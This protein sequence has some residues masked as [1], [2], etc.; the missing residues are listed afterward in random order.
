MKPNNQGVIMHTLNMNLEGTT[1]A[2]SL[3]MRPPSQDERI[4]HQKAVEVYNQVREKDPDR[5]IAEPVSPKN[6]ELS[7]AELFAE[8]IQHAFQATVKKA[9][10]KTL[11]KINDISLQLRAA[12][13]NNGI[14]ELSEED[15][16]YIRS[17]FEA[18]SEWQVNPEIIEVILA[19][20]EAI[21]AAQTPTKG[22]TNAS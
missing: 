19:M 22:E 1:P 15:Y 5:D 4:A 10:S 14:A 3:R 2:V 20:Q 18:C 9:N 13:K 16:R 6:R 11:A 17:K 8:I 21:N 7:N 12:A